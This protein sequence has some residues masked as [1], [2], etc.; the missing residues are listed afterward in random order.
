MGNMIF[1]SLFLLGWTTVGSEENA[2]FLLSWK[3]EDLM[4]YRPRLRAKGLWF[5][6]LRTFQIHGSK[7]I[8][9]FLVRPPCSS[10]PAPS[11]FLCLIL[12]KRRLFVATAT[13]VWKWHFHFP[14]A[15]PYANWLTFCGRRKRVSCHGKLFP[16]AEDELNCIF[17]VFVKLRPQE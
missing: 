8:Q 10:P 15:T 2:R 1:L 12:F 5:P 14:G 16:L 9:S 7:S 4:M 6:T 13:I 11:L 17:P 3:T